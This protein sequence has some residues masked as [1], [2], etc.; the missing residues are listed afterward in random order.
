MNKKERP[1]IEEHE[2][3]AQDLARASR[4]L[5]KVGDLIERHYPHSAQPARIAY[6]Y[7]WATPT[8]VDRMRHALEDEYLKEHRGAATTPYTNPRWQ[9]TVAM[10]GDNLK[11]EVP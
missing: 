9:E 5:K 1:T 8:L 11:R 3:I 6:A 2:G 7:F 4:L 10:H